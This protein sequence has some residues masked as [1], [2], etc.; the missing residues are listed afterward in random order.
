MDLF[1]LG[2]VLASWRVLTREYW[3]TQIVPADARLWAKL[4]RRIPERGLLALYRAT[5]F[6]GVCRMVGWNLYA[7][8]FATPTING[9]KRR[10]YPFD[11]SW[12]GPWW[13]KAKSLPHVNPLI[14]MPVVIMMLITLYWTLGKL[15]DRMGAAERVR[16]LPPPGS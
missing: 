7:H 2:V 3:R 4:G 10:G 13:T 12:T 9:V 6:F 8:V 11:L 1:W 16:E 15:W 5:F 14:V